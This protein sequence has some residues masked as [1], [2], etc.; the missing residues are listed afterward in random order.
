MKTIERKEKE[1]LEINTVN[2]VSGLDIVC[3]PLKSELNGVFLKRSSALR[4]K[5]EMICVYLISPP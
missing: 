1:G 3:E 4:L 2:M 5:D